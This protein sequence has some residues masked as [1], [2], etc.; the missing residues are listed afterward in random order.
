MFFLFVS[1][2]RPE[3]TISSPIDFGLSAICAESL[4]AGT[5]T[6]VLS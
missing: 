2:A 1:E 6:S 3:T 4:P 5:F